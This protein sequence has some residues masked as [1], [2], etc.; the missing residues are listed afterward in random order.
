ML[1]CMEQ[2]MGVA[3]NR[4]WTRVWLLAIAF[5]QQ[6]LNGT[7]RPMTEWVLQVGPLDLQVI[8]P[9][10]SSITLIAGRPTRYWKLFGGK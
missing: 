4:P 5:D 8:L 3:Y 10:A 2:G 7:W 6:R 1:H 9:A